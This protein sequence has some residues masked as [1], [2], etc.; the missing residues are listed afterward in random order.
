MAFEGGVDT[1]RTPYLRQALRLCYSGNVE[2]R[3]KIY[4]YLLE[5][6]RSICKIFLCPSEKISLQVLIVL[7]TSLCVLVSHSRLI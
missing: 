3:L 5:H 1:D 7:F 4:T 6:L 2:V